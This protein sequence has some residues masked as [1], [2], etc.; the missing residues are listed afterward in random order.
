VEFVFDLHTVESSSVV[1]R[2]R[3]ARSDETLEEDLARDVRRAPA[4]SYELDR[5][6]EVGVALCDP[7]RERKG[8]TGFHEHMEAPAFDL[9]ALILFPLEDRQLFHPA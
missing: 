1:T 7:F 4:P 2:E 5:L 8:I 3:V 6:V 9:A